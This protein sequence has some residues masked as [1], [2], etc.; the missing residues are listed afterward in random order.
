MSKAKRKPRF[1]GS[2]PARV[3]Q[4]DHASYLSGLHVFCDGACEPNPG[5]GGWGFAAFLDGAEIFAA[6]GGAADTTNNVMELTGALEALR[7]IAANA[8]GRSARL[9]C[10]S[11]YVV[12][13]CNTWRHNWKRKG[14]VTAGKDPVKNMQL[15]QALDATLVAFPLVLEWVK[16]HAGVLGNERAD[17]LSLLGIREV[18]ERARDPL[19]ER[20]AQIMEAS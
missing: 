17:E 15:W 18:L 10:D 9:H 3:Y 13:G 1:R 20:F 16:G 6:H 7:W 2:N 8:A 11:Q 14:W 12:N 5:T 19:T 4:I